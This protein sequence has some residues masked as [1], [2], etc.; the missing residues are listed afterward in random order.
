MTLLFCL[1]DTYVLQPETPPSSAS[2]L[3]TFPF[4]RSA[5][6][7]TQVWSS[8]EFSHLEMHMEGQLL[9]VKNRIANSVGH[10]IVFRILRQS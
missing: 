5:G 9:S 2:A 8:I 1:Q 6:T 10:T 3:Y 7:H 4:I